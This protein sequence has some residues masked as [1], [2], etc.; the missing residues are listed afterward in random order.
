ME[1]PSELPLFPLDMVLLP[2]R[3]V[4]LHIFEERYKQMISECIE[5]ET[6]FGLV[7]GADQDFQEIG[8]AARVVNLLNQFPD[9]RMN[10]LIEGTKRFRVIQ[11]QDIHAYI[12]ALV[13]EID[14]DNEALD[15]DLGNR[16]KHLYAEALKLSLGWISPQ[17]PT[18]ELGA[19]SFSLAA[20]LNM[21]LEK[22]QSL[23]ENTSVNKRLEE[24]SDALE[25]SLVTLREVKR[26]TRGNG[27]LI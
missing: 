27:H 5:N 6:E 18:E 11:R 17:M 7:W 1:S 24:V 25:K 8:C 20:N 2:R 21:P 23:L 9:G 4:P 26:R 14:D 16:T 12:S 3:R 15:L 10:I 22:Q 13:E 19:L